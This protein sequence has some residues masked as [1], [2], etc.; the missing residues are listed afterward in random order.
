[1]VMFVLILQFLWLYIDDLVGKGLEW[2]V[3][4]ELILY[5]SGNLLIMA[6]PLSLLLASI[7]AVGNLGEHNELLALKASGISLPRI[8][9]PLVVVAGLFTVGDF[10]FANNALPY[11]NLKFS[12]LLYDVKQQRPELQIEEGVFYDGIKNYTIRVGDKDENTG[13]LR[14]VIIYDH[15]KGSGNR[16][17]TIA[18]SGYLRVTANQKYL[19]LTLYSGYSYEEESESSGERKLPFRTNQFGEQEAV[20]ELTGYGFE[21]TDENLFRDKAEMLNLSQLTVMSDSL[22][23][24]HSARASMQMHNFLYSE[25]FTHHYDFDTRSR[26][27]PHKITADSALLP[28][29]VEQRVAVAEKAINTAA[30]AQNLLAA[31]AED[32]R[33][34]NLSLNKHN[35]EWHLKFTNPLA[36]IILFFI[37]AALGAIIRKGGLG[38][39]FIVSLVVFLIYY[40]V[41]AAF[42]R[43]AR[44]G[45]W[46]V[47]M[48]IWMSTLVT[49]PM[50]IF[51]TYK[52]VGDRRFTLP[53]W[54][55]AFA[56]LLGT[57]IKKKG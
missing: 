13:L 24:E 49:L 17:V 33:R 14:R 25:S 18:D 6:L 45:S 2:S 44:D 51:F 48:A 29:S 10:F 19:I 57:F 47:P 5:A 55:V 30:Q 50:A 54:Y 12:S 52:A 32:L 35:I 27:K 22:L 4:A 42:K 40:M 8:M 16:A 46:E 1:M 41:S 9:A 37:G 38:M 26:N 53:K 3:I 7:M 43:L 11:I 21:R 36:C 15:S 39:P 31:T 56:N 20:F 28:L 23:R 34:A